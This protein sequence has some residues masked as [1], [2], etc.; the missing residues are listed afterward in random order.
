MNRP[1]H[2]STF[3]RRF[4]FA[5][6]PDALLQTFVTIIGIGVSAGGFIAY[7]VLR[8][9]RSWHWVLKSFVALIIVGAS[10]VVS[11]LILGERLYHLFA[12]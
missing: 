12:G 8:E 9:R 10:V 4:S 1:V 7:L 5:D 6:S 11:W 2:R 3:L